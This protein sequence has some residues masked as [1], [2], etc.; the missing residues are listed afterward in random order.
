MGG[1]WSALWP[2]LLASAL[3]GPPAVVAHHKLLK[4]K[5][6]QKLDELQ[7]ETNRKL[8]RIHRAI[9]EEEAAE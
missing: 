7:A 1:L 2:N 6:R 3:W 5:I 8:D 9:T 4:T